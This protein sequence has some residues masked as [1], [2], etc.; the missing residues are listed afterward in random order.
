MS[1]YASAG[2][3]AMPCAPAARKD[4]CP[5]CGARTAQDGID[6]GVGIMPT[7]NRYCVKCDWEE[8]GEADFGFLTMDERPFAPVDPAQ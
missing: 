4:D 6:V 2:G 8:S 1:G 7:G 3:F 5:A